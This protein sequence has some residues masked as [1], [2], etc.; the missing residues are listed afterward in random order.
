MLLQALPEAREFV[1][2]AHIDMAPGRET[3]IRITLWKERSKKLQAN[4]LRS[5]SDYYI[6]GS[7]TALVPVLEGLD[8]AA[9]VWATAMRSRFLGLGAEISCAILPT[10]RASVAPSAKFVNFTALQAPLLKLL[11]TLWGQPRDR[12]SGYG[13][14]VSVHLGRTLQLLYRT[15]ARAIPTNVRKHTMAREVLALVRS[16]YEKHEQ[17]IADERWILS[18]TGTGLEAHEPEDPA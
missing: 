2:V 8:Q 3:G 11:D 5:G 7:P 17:L 10:T 16:L 4:W 9:S 14:Q 12:W 15:D 6:H 1:A 13:H 18:V